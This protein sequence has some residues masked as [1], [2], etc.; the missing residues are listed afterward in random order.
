MQDIASKEQQ[1]VQSAPMAR[2]ATVFIV[3]DEP[4]VGEVVSALL[5]MEGLNTR[6]FTSPLD[7][8]EAFEDA[9]E[10]PDL[11]ITDFAMQPFDGIQL[12]TRCLET[13]PNLRTILYSGNTGMDTEFV[14]KTKADAYLNKPFLPKELIAKV[15]ALV[16]R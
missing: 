13:H 10:K 3:D 16:A 9:E 2:K 14:H 6:L 7:A 15:H 12:M 8:L 4:M 11:L 5:S 1:H